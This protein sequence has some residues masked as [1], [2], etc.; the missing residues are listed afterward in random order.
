MQATP[1][2]RQIWQVEIR[3]RDL[4]KCIAFYRSVFNWPIFPVGDDY[5]MIDTG[6]MPVGS[7]LM[8][9][10]PKFPLGVGDFV[11]VEDC[12]AAGQQAVALGGRICVKKWEVP[13]SGW[14][15]GTLDP[16]G[17]ELWFWE[18]KVHTVPRL[19]AGREHHYCWLEIPVLDL[20][21]GV[22]YYSKLLG[23]R[24]QGIEQ[25]S[26]YAF[27]QDGGLSMGASIV[28]GTPGKQML[29]V[30]HG[31]GVTNYVTAT[32]LS[33]LAERVVAGGGK[34]VVPPKSL[35]EGAFLVFLDPEEN[36]LAAFDPTPR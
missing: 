34:V 22:A 36:K 30:Q 15:V 26:D 31:R 29:S 32:G 11:L 27:T 28:G 12:A 25:R 17:N 2:I 3:T 24:F 7:I 4:A 10:D 18:P 5:A 1:P 16:W 33:Q 19:R 9:A 23:W 14:F 35:G 8:T 6:I 13:N 20:A 21:Q